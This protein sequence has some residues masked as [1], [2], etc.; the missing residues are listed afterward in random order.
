LSCPSADTLEGSE[1][2]V[3]GYE[4]DA[5]VDEQSINERHTFYGAK[6]EIDMKR[7][8]SIVWRSRGANETLSIH[9]LAFNF[10]SYLLSSIRRKSEKYE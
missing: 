2:S 6:Y 5:V 8:S 7:D 1:L 10:F 9:E 4:G 3:D